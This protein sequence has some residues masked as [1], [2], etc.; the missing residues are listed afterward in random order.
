[1]DKNNLGTE[2]SLNVTFHKVIPNAKLTKGKYLVI[3]P[4]YVFGEPGLLWT[5]ICNGL[6]HYEETCGLGKVDSVFMSVVTKSNNY[7]VLIFGTAYG[8]GVYPV[9]DDGRCL[10]NAGVDA[11]LLSFIPA[12]LIKEIGASDRLGVWVELPESASIEV[13]NGDARIGSLFVDTGGCTEDNE[14][15]EDELDD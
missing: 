14:D 1:M 15:D 12:E 4:C 7:Q 5:T 6:S 11:G 2:S 8:D 9:I 13:S 10:G 3:D